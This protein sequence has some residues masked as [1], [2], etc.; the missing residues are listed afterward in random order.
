MKACRNNADGRSVSQIAHDFFDHGPHIQLHRL[1]FF[2]GEGITIFYSRVSSR[3]Q[4]DGCL[5]FKC[6]FG[7]QANQG[8]DG[9]EEAATR[10]RLNGLDAASD[11]RV[12]YSNLFFRHVT[13][14]NA[15]VR[16]ECLIAKR[17]PKI[18]EGHAPGLAHCG[19]AAG[20]R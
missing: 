16:G 3:F 20:E 1:T 12:D 15:F 2:E 10:R 9:I 17:I 5:P 4:G 19:I 8:G 18:A 11:H 14:G 13:A 6:H 7:S